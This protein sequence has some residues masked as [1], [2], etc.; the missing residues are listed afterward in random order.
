M[1]AQGRAI[2][3]HLAEQKI[4]STCFFGGQGSLCGF[5]AK[6][7]PNVFSRP[8]NLSFQMGQ[9]LAKLY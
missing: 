1:I 2:E 8:S 6:F 3:H 4:D 5:F 9:D 7:I